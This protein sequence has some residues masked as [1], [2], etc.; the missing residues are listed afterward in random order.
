M[1]KHHRRNVVHVAIAVVVAITCQA[2]AGQEVRLRSITVDGGVFT[3]LDNHLIVRMRSA[4]SLDAVNAVLPRGV[5]AYEHLLSPLQSTYFQSGRDQRITSA[6]DLVSSSV[7]AMELYRAE[8]QLTRTFLVRYEG[9]RD[10]MRIVM[11]VR[12][13]ASDD[14][15]IAEPWYVYRSAVGPNDPGRNE[16]TYLTTIGFDQTWEMF[17][18]SENVTIGISDDGIQQAHEDLTSNIAPNAAEI[19]DNGVDDDGNGFVDDY[20]G[21]NFTWQIDSDLPGNTSS[22]S[23]FGHGTKVAGIAAAATNNAIGIAGV[24]M[25]TRFFPL[26][27][28]LRNGTGILFGYQSLIYAA[29]RGFPVV[30]CSWGLVKPSSAI[31][32]SVID[33]CLAK[34][35]LVVASA[36]NHGDDG[37]GSAFRQRNFPAA[38]EGVLG[39]GETTPDDFVVSS[40]G[41]GRNARVMAPGNGAYTTD[42]GGGYTANG[43]IG[44]SFA[45]PIVAGVA[46]IV[47][48]RWPALSARQIAAHICRTA[49]DITSKNNAIAA[50]LSPRVNLYRAVTTEPLSNSFLRLSDVRRRISSGVPANRFRAGDTVV[51]EF[52]ITN[53]LAPTSAEVEPKVIDANGWIVRILSERDALGVVGTGSTVWSRPFA[54]VVEAIGSGPCLM[55]V[56]LLSDAT[57]ERGWYTIE[58]P[59][60]IAQFS[61]D[62]LI[63]SMSDDGMVGYTSVDER[64]QGDGF[65]K[66][67]SFQLMSPGGFFMID[68]SDRSL[69]GF[70]NDPP[71]ASDFRPTK[72]FDA[73]PRPEQ[74][75]MTDEGAAT[76]VGVLVQQ[77]CTFPRPDRAATIWRVR[78]TPTAAMR[79]IGAGYLLDWDVGTAG[80]SNTI[81]TN[82]QLLPVALR[83]PNNA[84]QTITRNGY[85]IVVN[86]AVISDDPDDV[87]QSA[88]FLY[89]SV[90]DD[91]DGF[92]HA[93]RVRLLTSGVQITEAGEGDICGVVGMLH[94]KPLESGQS[95][96]FRV[97]VAVGSDE[98]AARS[99]LHEALSTVSVSYDPPRAALPLVEPNPVTDDA[100][101][102][103]QPDVK[104]CR[105]IDALGR[106][107]MVWTHDGSRDVR[108]ST[109]TLEPG[110]YSVIMESATTSQFITARFVR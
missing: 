20:R 17:R 57:I 40:S 3:V 91:G 37:A 100:V 93:D 81:R 62:S 30:N 22:N 72:T 51:L 6:S 80:R 108:F 42:V 46:G 85:P 24:G 73:A 102:R 49:D 43:V 5:R 87:A 29:Q 26:K 58:P 47:R 110:A 18:G 16:Q 55:R 101:I 44:T 75:L 92:T 48:A 35:T 25:A 8:E 83:T 99:T 38:Y 96:S 69:S 11:D 63:Y 90:I 50:V 54:C 13:A 19:P 65:A 98:D 61:N 78:V 106:Q 56:D 33:Y 28:A 7:Q 74:C 59:A 95:W 36:G 41:L 67:P 60:G 23:S 107:R 71:Y 21:Y 97:V 9:D 94:T 31:D 103:E 70:K 53:D 76:P 34:N 105:V 1:P 86:V 64:R 88:G 10:P 52:G 68:G 66:R 39:V 12:K 27:T 4:R 45:S 82:P 2:L 77:E 15:E 32:Q 109:V 84:C 79:S 14:V 89:A 104:R